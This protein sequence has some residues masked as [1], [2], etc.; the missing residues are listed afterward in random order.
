MLV[1]E[2]NH[3]E[4]YP[5]GSVVVVGTWLQ[6]YMLRRNR[7]LAF[8]DYQK[9]KIILIYSHLIIATNVKLLKHQGRPKVKELFSITNADHEALLETLKER[10]DPTGTLN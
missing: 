7:I 5:S 8:K 3:Q 4:T 9:H 2:Q 10:E 1:V 6:T